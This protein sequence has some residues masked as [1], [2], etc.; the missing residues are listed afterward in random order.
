MTINKTP[1]DKQYA[2][3]TNEWLKSKIQ[4][5][6]EV[7]NPEWYTNQGVRDY[8]MGLSTKLNQIASGELGVSKIELGIEPEKSTV[9][10]LIN[11]DITKAGKSLGVETMAMIPQIIGGGITK[12]SKLFIGAM[13][14][15]AAGGSLEKQY[16]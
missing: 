9:D 13:G 12:G 11:G 4:Q 6:G 10:H 1:E 16:G 14:A 7:K 15:V 5:Q 3:G 8:F 2:I